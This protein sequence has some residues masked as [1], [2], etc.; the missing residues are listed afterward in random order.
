MILIGVL[1][2]SERDFLEFERNNAKPGVK[3]KIVRSPDNCSCRKF[4]DWIKLWD[5]YRI[6]RP[7]ETFEAV[8][9]RTVK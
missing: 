2:N 3:Y 6:D 9:R 4:N 8:K 5:W 7:D 1:T